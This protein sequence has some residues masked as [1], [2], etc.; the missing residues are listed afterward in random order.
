VRIALDGVG[1]AASFFRV[2]DAATPPARGVLTDIMAQ[3][4]RTVRAGL[5][6]FLYPGRIVV[7]CPLLQPQG[8]NAL[9]MSFAIAYAA[10]FVSTAF[11]S[12]PTADA[13]TQTVNACHKICASLP[14]G[15]YGRCRQ[16]CDGGQCG[17]GEAAGPD[18]EF[19][20]QP[21]F[22]WGSRGTRILPRALHA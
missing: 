9:R 10:I 3:T 5:L 22:S 2:Y 7:A 6:V 14:S 15:A 21:V 18:R 16:T 1:T 11:V 13:Q 17:R 12:I 20:Q 4:P 19:L 8:A